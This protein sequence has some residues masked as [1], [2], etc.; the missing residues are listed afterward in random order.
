M[1]NLT[2]KLASLIPATQQGV[3]EYHVFPSRG[4]RLA[5]PFNGQCFRQLM[6]MDLV[7]A[8][9]FDAIVETGT[10]R[11]GTTLFMARNGGCHVHSVELV[12]RNH[13]FAARRLRNEANVALQIGDSRSFLRNIDLDAQRTIFFYLDAHWYD[14][15]PLQEEVDIIASRFVH[16]VCM[17]DDFEVPE[18]ADYTFDDYGPGKRLCLTDFPF[19][20]D[21]RLQ[22]FFPNRPGRR[23][24]GAKRGSVVLGSRTLA[25]R[26]RGIA[27][28]RP[29][30]VPPTG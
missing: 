9:R 1:G 27:S 12:A 5:G 28:L 20:E 7:H 8:C 17:V 22:V 29:F 14:D 10:F 25:E 18:D 26:L 23:E 15:L 30:G 3:L 4:E 6:F 2:S 19:H 21:A 11:G 16:F 24:S 13:G